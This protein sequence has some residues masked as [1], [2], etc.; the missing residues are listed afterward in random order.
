MKTM[1][2]ILFWLLT[3]AAAAAIAQVP[4]DF[5]PKVVSSN[6]FKMSEAGEKAG[7]DGTVLLSIRVDE[8]GDV[9]SAEVVS[10]PSWPCGQNPATE[11]NELRS[12]I[13]Q[14]VLASKF[15][16][17][18]KKGKP[19]AVDLWIKFM[20]GE[21]YQAMLR[22]RAMEEAIKN[23]MPAPV[24]V[25]GGILNGRALK[26]PVPDYPSAARMAHASGAVPVEIEIDL[27]GNVARAGAVG[28]H[29]SL[30]IAART[31]A[32]EAKFSPTIL[33]GNPVRVHGVVTYN[34]NL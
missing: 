27:E 32:C 25:K 30:Q 26:L 16:P 2:P 10:G 8:K 3:F 11:L 13:R 29:P 19:R 15:S 5:E 31:A 1:L 33:Q 6:V 20:V 14:N 17:A 21:S 7:I 34:F 9:R 23:G 22:N 18:I 24:I 4:P 12:E 28:G